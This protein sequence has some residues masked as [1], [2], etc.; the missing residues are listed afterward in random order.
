MFSRFIRAMALSGIALTLCFNAGILHAEARHGI[1]MYGDPALPS[2][3]TSLPQV[4]PDAPKGGTI[5]MGESGGFDNLNPFVTMGRPAAGITPLVVESLMGRNYDEPFTLY[6]LIAETVQTDDSRSY[7]EFTLRDEARFSDG[8]PVTVEDVLWSM[9]VLGTI[10]NPRYHAAWAKV[11]SAIQTGPRSVR[12][13]F[14]AQ[15]REL[16]LILGLRPILKKSQWEGRDFESSGLEAPIGS[17]PYLVDKVDPGIS[18]TYRRNPDWWGKDLPFNRGQWNFDRI[19]YEYFAMPQAQFEA[20]KSGALSSYRESSAVR[21]NEIYNFPAVKSDRI[22]KSEIPHQRPSG[23]AGLAFNTR[24]PPFDDWKVREAL[25]LAFDFT[26]INKIVTG[27]L[28]PRIQSYFSNSSLG[29]IPGQPASARAAELLAPYADGLPAGALDGYSLPAPQ[30]PHEQ[31]QNMRRAAQLL[32]EAGWHP[33]L[34]GLLRDKDGQPFRFEI[35]LG[36]GQDDM[37]AAASNY[38]ETLNALGIEA[39]VTV[40]DSAQMKMRTDAYDFDMTYFARLLSLSPGNEQILYWGSGAGR[41][42]GS[43]NWPGVNSIAVDAMI[44]HMLAAQSP[45]EF[46]AAVE[47]LDRVLTAGRYV[48][49]VWYSD[50]SRIA[51]DRKLHFSERVPLYGDWSGFQPDIWWYED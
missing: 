22:V 5:V 4:N 49:P 38:A 47:A 17:G 13:N 27:G 39:I 11:E 32:E 37:I 30:S 44:N 40:I 34:K 45:E 21:W 18:I 33:D 43:R 29:M 42:P 51:H 23:I 19:R 35:L 7:V 10:G 20:F 24:R 15:D 14:S 9:E 31:R 41:H 48:I 1:A 3:F 6:G 25:I 26:A 46:N 16:P 2:D 12:F 28:E 50:R 8:S 36:V